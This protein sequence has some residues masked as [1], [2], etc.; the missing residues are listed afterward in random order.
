MKLNGLCLVDYLLAISIVF[1]SM[2]FDMIHEESFMI[3]IAMLCGIFT[4]YPMNWGL[5][6][7]KIKK[8]CEEFLKIKKRNYG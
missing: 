7:K 4:F 1:F 5:S 3:P 2:L 6:S 8:K